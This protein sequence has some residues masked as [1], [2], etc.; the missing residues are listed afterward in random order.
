MPK[1]KVT[2]LRNRGEKKKSKD[3]TQDLRGMD[4]PPQTSD[5]NLIEHY[6]DHLDR[7]QKKQQPKPKEEL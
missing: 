3:L 7:E 1:I 6:W 2:S 4:W 5:L